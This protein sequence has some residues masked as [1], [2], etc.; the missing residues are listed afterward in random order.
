MRDRVEAIEKGGEPA[1]QKL[2]VEPVGSEAILDTVGWPYAKMLLR[3]ARL[4]TGAIP[5]GMLS[6]C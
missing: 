4:L 6:D 5:H 2:I 1:H 3:L